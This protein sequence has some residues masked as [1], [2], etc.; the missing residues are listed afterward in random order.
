[1]LLYEA[2]YVYKT[3]HDPTAEAANSDFTLGDPTPERP[4]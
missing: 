4:F 3:K 2:V 1:M